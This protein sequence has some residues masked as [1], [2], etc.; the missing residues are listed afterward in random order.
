[1]LHELGHATFDAGLDPS[2]PWLLRDTHLVVTEGIAILMGRLAGDAEW[3]E[4]VLG[5]DP[6][7]VAALARRAPAGARRRAARLH[8]LGARDDELRALAL[9]RSRGGPRRALVGARRALPARAP[10]GRAQRARTGRRRS[11]WPARPSTTT[12]IS[13][14]NI[15]A[16]QLAATL[17]RE[18][19]GLVDRPEAGRLLARARLRARPLGALG[20]AD[21]AGDGRA[22]ERL[23]LR[24]RHRR[25]LSRVRVPAHPQPRQR[26]R[27]RPRGVE[28]LLRRR[29]RTRAAAD[30]RL[31][32]PGHL[33]RRR[34]LAGAPVRAAGRAAVAC[35]L[36]SRDRRVHARLPAHEGARRARPRHLRNR[37][38][39]EL[40]NGGVQMYVRDPAGNLVELDHRDASTIPRDEVPEYRTLA[41]QN[42]QEGEAAR[43]T[44]WHLKRP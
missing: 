12:T 23:A 43:A 16:S 21:R 44:L 7:A 10:P 15:V 14:G 20:P 29:A 17:E 37:D 18:C 38:V 8:A 24:P 28:A 30:A 36:R 31:R 6:A 26:R 25:R 11:T 42:P 9:R 40:P 3:L 22:A 2:L 33:A 27:H 19:G 5:V 13:T 34:R 41:D 1:M 39:R 4:R 35:S 32:L